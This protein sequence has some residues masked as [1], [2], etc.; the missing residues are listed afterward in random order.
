MLL[1]LL[2]GTGRLS[3]RADRASSLAL[4]LACGLTDRPGP[5]PALVTVRG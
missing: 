4:L 2:T 5:D 1:V 3:R